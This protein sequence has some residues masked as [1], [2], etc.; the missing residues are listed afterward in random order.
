MNSN[1]H[2]VLCT[3]CGYKEVTEASGQI[4]LPTYVDVWPVGVCVWNITVSPDHVV[5]LTIHNFDLGYSWHTTSTTSVY[6]D[7]NVEDE[8]SHV[9]LL[10]PNDS[11]GE[12]D[13]VAM[14]VYL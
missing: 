14:L 10:E 6:G 1:G 4:G 9:K 8:R 3:E 12:L 2:F 7:S 13:T 11:T 5:E